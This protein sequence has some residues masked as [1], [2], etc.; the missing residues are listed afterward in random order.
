M[1]D[2]DA[3]R[4]HLLQSAWRSDRFVTPSST[5]RAE[6]AARSHPGRVRRENEDHYLVLQLGRSQAPLMTSLSLRDVAPRFDERA[7]FAVV[8]DGVGGEGIGAAAARMAVGTLAELSVR[9]GRWTMRIDAETR[10]DLTDRAEWLFR[11]AHETVLSSRRQHPPLA[12]MATTLTGIYTAGTDLLVAHVG[13]S[14]CY[15]FRHGAL[16]LLTSDHTL[17]EHFSTSRHPASVGHVDDLRHILTDVVG[18]ASPPQIAIEHFEL[19][20]GDNIL[21]CTNGLTDAVDDDAISDVLASPRSP[22]EQCQLLIDAALAHGGEDNATV[23]LAHYEYA[24]R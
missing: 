19:R 13:H 12:R 7:Y 22:E 2:E 21:L 11:Q 14:R 9:F 10:V 16:T 18:A 23:V 24:E 17:H 8:A 20:D 1:S 3:G 15:L 5:V 4:R 6:F